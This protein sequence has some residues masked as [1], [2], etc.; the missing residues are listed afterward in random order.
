MRKAACCWHLP[1]L[2]RRSSHGIYL[3]E[4]SGHVFFHRGRIAA[5]YIL[6]LPKISKLLYSF[7]DS[8]SALCLFVFLL[9]ISILCKNN[10]NIQNSQCYQYTVVYSAWWTTKVRINSKIY[11]RC[12]L[13]HSD[14]LILKPRDFMYNHFDVS[15]AWSDHYLKVSHPCFKRGNGGGSLSILGEMSRYP[16]I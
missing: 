4:F 7:T 16:K 13:P 10:R 5:M 9:K 15:Y 14:D 6:Y 2:F 11:I 3:S 1:A 12:N 8:N